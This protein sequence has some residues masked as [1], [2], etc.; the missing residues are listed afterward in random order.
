[1]GFVDC[2]AD[3]AAALMASRL[4]VGVSAVDMA[5]AEGATYTGR[6]L[7]AGAPLDVVRRTL[8]ARGRPLGRGFI[9]SAVRG[10][11]MDVLHIICETVKVYPPPHLPNVGRVLTIIVV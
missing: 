4:F 11:R 7:E 1:M 5:I 3:V 9:E 8:A 2:A 6:L 10:G